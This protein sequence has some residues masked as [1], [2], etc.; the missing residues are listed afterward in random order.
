MNFY[1]LTSV[2]LIILLGTK[3]TLD[4]N[5]NVLVTLITIILLMMVIYRIKFESFLT[6]NNKTSNN[7]IDKYGKRYKESLKQSK[8]HDN[9]DNTHKRLN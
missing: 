4:I 1:F 9:I 7:I 3:D 5:F 2:A 6:L 8:F